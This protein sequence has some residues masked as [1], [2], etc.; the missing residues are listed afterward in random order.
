MILRAAHRRFLL[1][2]LLAFSLA[3]PL[4]SATGNEVLTVRAAGHAVGQGIAARRAAAEQA[5][6]DAVAQFVERT[7]TRTGLIDPEPIRRQA[8]DYIDRIELLRFDETEE[9]TRVEADVYLREAVIFQAIARAFKEAPRAT[10]TRKIGRAAVIVGEQFPLDTAPAVLD[11]GIVEKALVKALQAWGMD[12]QGCAIA[13]GI[14]THPELVAVVTGDVEQGGA[15]ARALGYDVVIAGTA[16]VSSVPEGPGMIRH[17]ATLALRFYRGF[18]GKMVESTGETQAVHGA[19]FESGPRQALRD[20]AAR[21]ADAVCVAATITYL[22]AG[23]FEGVRIEINAP[24]PRDR[25]AALAA[26]LRTWPGV[27][28]VDETAYTPAHARLD[29]DYDGPVIEIADLLDF[30]SIAGARVRI[31]RVIGREIQLTLRD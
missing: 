28:G 20:V 26:L 29:L 13:E 6:R 15:F 3:I 4:H 27:R 17:K 31:D 11:G 16:V 9:G 22:S 21:A 14:Y 25:V 8:T 18:D 10:P 1:T 23:A 19:G 2:V 5:G 7:V 30:S 12:A 24:G